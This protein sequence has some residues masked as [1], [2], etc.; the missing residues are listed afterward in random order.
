MREAEV[1]QGV[2][3]AEQELIERWQA[4]QAR[5]AESLESWG[6]TD[7]ERFVE[8]EAGLIV[9]LAWSGEP[10][11]T[12]EMKALCSYD[13][14]DALLMMAWAG[15][16]AEKGAVIDSVPDVPDYVEHCSEE[17]AWLWAMQLA[18]MSRADYLYR[19]ATPTY[20]VFLGLWNVGPALADEDGLLEGGTPQAFI[21]NLLDESR[22]ALLD[23]SHDSIALRRLFLNQ[24]DSLHQSA[25][26]LVAD[27]ADPRL[28]KQTVEMLLDIGQSF[29][30][31]RFGFLPPP[32]PT[33]TEVNA[34]HR[35]LLRLRS[36][37]LR[38]SR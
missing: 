25:Q 38:S 2:E 5:L 13:I 3:I 23:K 29:G 10:T 31:R 6:A 7:G 1:E 11:A 19:I 21:V 36:L 16:G 17:E 34:L 8:W 4:R 32:P 14:A 15:E 9:W 28:L 26:Y 35:T 37:W 33:A 22:H 12:A 20:L 24:G 18:E 30:Q 27:G